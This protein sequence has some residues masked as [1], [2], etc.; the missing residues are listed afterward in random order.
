MPRRRLDAE[1]VRRGLAGTTSDAAAAVA[2]GSVT[3]R[4]GPATNP[5]T[6]VSPDEAV[7]MLTD[8]RRFVSRGGDKLAAALAAFE[9]DA[10]GRDALDAGASTG[11]F[12]D[13]LLQ[14]GAAR[15]I[16]VDVG[17]GQLA[18]SLRMDPRVVVMERTNIRELDRSM[19]AFVP[20]L[21]VAD[22]SFVSLAGVVPDLV[23]I[24][25]KRAD[26]VL[27]VKPQFEAPP[28]EV[29]SGGVVRDP[30]ARRH[31]IQRVASACESVG[32]GTLAVMTSPI[33]GRA[34]NVEYLLHARIGAP[35]SVEIDGA[36]GDHEPAPGGA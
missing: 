31:A 13:C 18:W 11:G 33:A 7:H 23:S 35:G 29:P 10:G 2:A 14:E 17:Y 36:I 19:L 15:V 8:G 16:A 1:L 20:D 28:G 12:T 26:L 24:A 5:A 4:G 9:V 27:L 21:V 32:A 3:V 25:S 30:A 34:G 22:L 6:L